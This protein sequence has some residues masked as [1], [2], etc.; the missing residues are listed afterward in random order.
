MSLGITPTIGPYLLPLVLPAVRKNYPDFRLRIIEEQLK[1]LVQKVKNGELDIIISA[2]SYNVRG[3]LAFEF[4]EEDFY[5][6]AHRDDI[7]TKQ[8]EI[9]SADFKQ[10][11]IMLL[12]EG[13]CLND[14]ALAVCQLPSS[15]TDLLLAST[16][17]NTLV[18]MV[19]G[20]VGTTLVPAMAFG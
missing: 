6:L 16:S 3:L 4:W 18:K 17:L 10:V 12:K 15:V 7:L 9:F 14:H 20:R 1:V 13:Y 8:K 5:W 2:L 11:R 19:A